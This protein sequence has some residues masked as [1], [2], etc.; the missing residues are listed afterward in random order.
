MGQGPVVFTSG[1][2]KELRMDAML[3]AKGYIS[4]S[5]YARVEEAS[6]RHLVTHASKIS[7]KR[8]SNA[9]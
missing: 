4:G 2:P 8:S 7:S 1:L 3:K 6:R 9:L 5:L